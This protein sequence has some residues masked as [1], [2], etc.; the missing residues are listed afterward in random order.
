MQLIHNILFDHFIFLDKINKFGL[1][2]S[3]VNKNLI[4]NIFYYSQQKL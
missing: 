3:E 4:I 2:Q 1:K